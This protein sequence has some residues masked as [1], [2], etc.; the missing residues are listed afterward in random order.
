M[1][2]RY[3]TVLHIHKD[4]IL[5]DFEEEVLNGIVETIDFMLRHYNYRKEEILVMDV[6]RDVNDRSEPNHNK[7]GD[8]DVATALSNME[9]VYSKSCFDDIKQV[10]IR[11][12]VEW[13]RH[14]DM[15]WDMVKEIEDYLET[16]DVK[17]KEGESTKDSDF[18]YYYI[19]GYTTSDDDSCTTC[20]GENLVSYPTLD[21]NFSKVNKEVYDSMTESAK[22][23]INTIL[24]EFLTYPM[25]EWSMERKLTRPKYL[26]KVIDAVN[27]LEKRDVDSFVDMI[28]TI[29]GNITKD[30]WVDFGMENKLRESE[31]LHSID[32]RKL[33]LSSV[34]NIL[35]STYINNEAEVKGYNKNKYLLI[36]TQNMEEGPIMIHREVYATDENKDEHI[37]NLMN[38]I[39]NVSSIAIY[40]IEHPDRRLVKPIVDYVHDLK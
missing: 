19:S 22:E 14:H 1:G 20:V 13:C 3:N 7:V 27:F 34:F 40:K 32:D 31:E 5:R 10:A 12:N 29:V 2:A 6:E 25:G 38:T 23:V 26:V 28:K 18:H 21:D 4:R 9:S 37:T 17:N 24:S 11:Y 35:R 33:I 30:A 36:I 8:K 15:I 16:N 39:D